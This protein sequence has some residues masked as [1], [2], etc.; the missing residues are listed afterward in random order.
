MCPKNHKLNCL[1]CVCRVSRGEV[2]PNPMKDPAVAKKCG[3]SHRGTKHP[4]TTGERNSAKRPEVRRK[5]S[6]SKLGDQNP[7]RQPGARERMRSETLRRWKDPEF[8]RKQ[9]QSRNVR[10]NKA[11]KLL[12]SLIDRF[13][14]FCF[15]GDG[16]FILA[17]KCPDFTHF[18]KKLI[19][20][21]FGDY[22][23][24][25]EEVEPRI[26]LFEQNGYKTLVVWEH[27]L[28]DP[29]SVLLRITGFVQIAPIAGPPQIYYSH[30]I[31]GLCSDENNYEYEKQNCCTAIENVLWLR[32]H[33]PQVK[34]YCPG[35][36]EP[37]IVAAR[38]LGFLTV[39]QILE[40]DYHIVKTQCSA[41]L[42]H[43]WEESNGT[44]KEEDLI[45]KLK[46]PSLVLI[47]SRHISECPIY[48]IRALVDSVL[49]NVKE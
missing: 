22:W 42:I 1:C 45:I 31:R 39:Q 48:R 10:Q 4:S 9:I 25:P 6:R 21:L 40:I 18:R 20:E 26:K 43:R 13:P 16:K 34:W 15:T 19:I 27:E 23:H 46:Y 14:G 36:V 3:L 47:E 49:A 35:E 17:G 32:N 37:P 11:E 8:V 33:F 24:K 12:E 2:F 5:I 29:N 7:S 30:P 38:L 41:G 44:H 28:G